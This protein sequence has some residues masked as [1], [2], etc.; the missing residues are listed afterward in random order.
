[1]FIT[2]KGEVRESVISSDLK[3]YSALEN[4]DPS[5]FKRLNYAKEMLLNL[6]SKKTKKHPMFHGEWKSDAKENNHGFSRKKSQQSLKLIEFYS[7]QRLDTERY[8]LK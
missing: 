4:T 5:M 1:M 6:I 8:Q 7:T 3:T 2:S